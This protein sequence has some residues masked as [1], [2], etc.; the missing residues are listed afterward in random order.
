M[1]RV[2]AQ[3]VVKEL[4]SWETSTA[5]SWGKIRMREVLNRPLQSEEGHRMEVVWDRKLLRQ[6][7]DLKIALGTIRN[8]VVKRSEKVLDGLEK[9]V[10]RNVRARYKL[11][12]LKD[13]PIIR[14]YRDFYWRLD[15]DPTKIRPAGE[16][17]IRRVIRGNG[18]PRILNV[19]DACNLASVETCLAFSAYDLDRL[20]PP[21]RVRFSRINETFVAIG[22]RIPQKLTGKEPVL[23]D[24][25]QILGLYPHRDAENSKVTKST[26]DILLVVYGVPAIEEQILKE[27]LAKSFELITAVAG[28]TTGEIGVKPL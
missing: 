8:A 21:L 26:K 7:P 2:A 24:E 23:T 16:A 15:I 6:L 27:G 10:L 4:G 14:A 17:L 20:E 13:E 19:V 22:K 11:Q 1:R 3:I 9:T 12:S 5:E 18:I 25:M 28:G